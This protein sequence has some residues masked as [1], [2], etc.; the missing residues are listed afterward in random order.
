MRKAAI[1]I[2]WLGAFGP[3]RYS[4]SKTIDFE[5]NRTDEVACEPL[6]KRNGSLTTG[7]GYRCSGVGLVLSPDSIFKVFWKDCGSTYDGDQAHLWDLNH[8]RRGR[9]YESEVNPD[10]NHSEAWAKA[11]NAAVA[12]IVY[13]NLCELPKRTQE[14]VLKASKKHG[15]KILVFTHKGEIKS[16]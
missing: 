6:W 11:E 7:V 2:R 3:L 12:I 9:L 4:L 16:L 14:E 5:V 13:G 8:K 1:Y 15:L 10:S